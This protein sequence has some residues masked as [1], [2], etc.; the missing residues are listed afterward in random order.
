MYCSH[1]DSLVRIGNKLVSRKKIEESLDSIWYWRQQGYSQQEVARKLSLERSFISRLE[2][3]GEIRKGKRIAVIGFPVKNKKEISDQAF[4]A[5][6]EYVLLM[7][8]EERWNLINKR[9]ALDFFN[10]VTEQINFLKEFDTL[11][12]LSSDKWYQLALAFL[13]NQ[14][15]FVSLGDSPL[16][17]DCQINPKQIG[18]LLSHLTG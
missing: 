11:L 9:S 18:F 12:L 3:M 16:K 5:G 6:A 8:D 14:I 7:D 17:Q 2:S 13:N 10:Y 1:F 4:Q 15:V